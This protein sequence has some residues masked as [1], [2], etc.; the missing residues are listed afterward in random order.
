M[1]YKRKNDL[2]LIKVHKL[3]LTL[4]FDVKVAPFDNCVKA[5]GQVL[6][7]RGHIYPLCTQVCCISQSSYCKEVIG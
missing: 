2:K 6:T 5:I 7:P 1:K 3:K 4:L